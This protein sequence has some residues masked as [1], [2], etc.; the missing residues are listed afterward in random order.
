MLNF[1]WGAGFLAY[2][3][4]VF[5]SKVEQTLVFFFNFGLYLLVGMFQEFSD[6]GVNFILVPESFSE[7]P[8]PLIMLMKAV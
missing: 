7:L 1:S 5:R 8:N 4:L 2:S 6:V 3:T